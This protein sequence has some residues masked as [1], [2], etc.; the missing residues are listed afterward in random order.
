MGATLRGCVYGSAVGDAL[1]VPFEFMGRGSFRCTDMVGYGTHGKPAGTWS[2]DT[3]MTIAT[4]DSIRELG[5]IDADDMRARFERWI[6]DGAYT[7]D[8]VFDF[9]GTTHRALAGG[10]GCAGVRD[11]G[12]GSLM[13]IAPL[14]FAGATD[15]EVREVSAI[16]HAHETSTGACVRLVRALRSL[17]GG[18]P[19]EEV[20]RACGVDASAPVEEVRSSGYVIHTLEAA[21]WCLARTTCYAECVLAAVNLGGDT[22]TTAAVAGALAGTAYGES[23]IPDRWVGALRA[24]D[25]I[26]GCL[27]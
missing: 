12:N 27:F 2:D 24:R 8:G 1:G 7:V 26:D 16:T 4:C 17:A 15:D 14:A 10:S 22:D 21:L 3:S 6:F 13:R 11:N 5:R 18:A 20:A 23:S 19:P 25:V 9:G